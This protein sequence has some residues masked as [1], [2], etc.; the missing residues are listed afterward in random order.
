MDVKTI[1]VAVDGSAATESVLDVAE[2]VANHDGVERVAIA[3]AMPSAVTVADG[4]MN[5]PAAAVDE[6]ART[7]QD[8]LERAEKRL[9]DVP[10]AVETYLLRGHDIAETLTSFFETKQCDLVVMGN[11]GLGGVK[12]YLGS[13][14]RKVLLCS[15]C[16]VLVVKCEEK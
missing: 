12:G 8:L 7:A 16:P 3:C 6:M 2:F 4:V 15:S 11:R 9:A 10:C 14:S 13:V 5:F 1:G